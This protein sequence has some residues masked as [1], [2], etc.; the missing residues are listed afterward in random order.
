MSRP[1]KVDI[2][3]FRWFL[4][5]PAIECEVNG[6]LKD[7][8]IIDTGSI[9][10]ATLTKKVWQALG[11]TGDSPGLVK[12]VKSVGIHGREFPIWLMRIKSLKIASHELKSPVIEVQPVLESG[13]FE[14]EDANGLIGNEA[15]KHFKITIDYPGQLIV[16]ERAADSQVENRYA[17]IGV[18]VI[19]CDG[20]Y[21]VKSVWQ[22]SPAQEA[23]IREGDEILAIDDRPVGTMTLKQ[24]RGKIKGKAGT[25]VKLKLRR[26]KE[27]ISLVVERRKL[28]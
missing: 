28:I 6:S 22:P 26:E 14:Y 17:S 21:L 9:S 5:R 8:F 13:M 4:G 27:L 25:K 20:K 3:P 11:I 1:G 18:G 7:W 15:L 2:V 12:G 10:A 19:A 16:L 24:V 23:G